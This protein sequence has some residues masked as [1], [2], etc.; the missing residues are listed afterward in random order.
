MKI[1]RLSIQ[2]FGGL[3]GFFMD[4]AGENM[5]LVYGD[6]E[7]G[8]S[9]ITEF[10]RS[11]M[12]PGKSAKY[13]IPKKSDN[14]ILELEMD[15][16]GVRILQRDQKKVV[17]KDGKLLPSVEL[18]MD[19][20]TYRSLFALDLEQL[21]D[22]KMITSG[23]LKRKFLTVPGGEHVPSVSKLI[24]SE[25]DA[26]L[27]KERLSD[28]K[29]IG[30]YRK[31]IKRLDAEIASKDESVEQYNDLVK[32]LD[33][34][35]EQLN[36]VHGMQDNANYIRNREFMLESLKENM[37]AIED[38]RKER[39]SLAYS[40]DLTD[41]DLMRY[42][43]L[44]AKI[45]T[46]DNLLGDME[47]E[48]ED[49]GP[50][51]EEKVEEIVAM[52]DDIE[53]VWGLKTRLDILTGTLNDLDTAKKEDDAYIEESCERLGLSEEQVCKIGSNPDVR[54]LLQNPDGKRT[55]P[56]WFFKLFSRG[57]R[58]LYSLAS[59]LGSGAGI[60]LDMPY[61][62][63]LSMAAG[64]TVNVMPSIMDTYFHV[65]NIV[66]SEWLPE[67]GFPV[68]MNRAQAA[69]LSLR[70]DPIYDHICRRR[71][72]EERI[73][74]F[75]EELNAIRESI[76]LVLSRM[77]I[78]TGNI[79]GDLNEMYS[80]YTL[81]KKIRHSFSEADGL[82]DKKNQTETEFE[83]IVSK[84]G[85]EEAIARMRSDREKLKTLDIQLDALTKSVESAAGMAQDVISK[86]IRPED[87][88]EDESP[89]SLEDR[90]GEINQEIGHV[91]AEMNAIRVDTE[92]DELRYQRS[93]AEER[94]NEAARRW[95]VLSLA[96]T[97]IN[98]CC[99]LFY[100]DLQPAVVRTA[101]RYLSLMT[102]G[103]YHI[104]SD[105]RDS[106]LVIEDRVQR[107]NADE[108]SSGLGDQV[109]LSVK[110]AVAK[111]M[112]GEKVPFLMDDVLVRFDRDR[113]QGACRAIM[114]FAKDQQVIMFTCDRS[115]ES[116]FR[117][118]GDIKYI[119]L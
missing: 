100:T 62:T 107:K 38:L 115:L 80:Q 37:K 24:R 35:N 63:V 57:K 110:M 47:P 82:T 54:E 117:L 17:E 116:V 12:F 70:V 34:L 97:I 73:V 18:H 118:E 32:R 69:D 95:A 29:V 11:T 31:E 53:N 40:E 9:T 91:N 78:D 8:K 48:V 109:Y 36:Y 88:E 83:A 92:I 42:D 108:W 51:S 77:N 68:G 39:E 43:E 114:E 25:M 26:L 119:R 50:M 5:V 111:E 33:V 16:G 30:K 64:I 67:N 1:R 15:D 58:Y 74:R 21:T 3:S 87:Q 52:G 45:A 28:A 19:A 20:E 104:I 10:M 90:I 71:I 13:P 96:D 94:F 59:I 4:L 22:D 72:T 89:E 81:A 103:R 84:Y 99:S 46:L 101:N 27:N 113:K 112:G 105:P 56:L 49:N 102:N 14:G 66:W 2:S 93:V 7:A 65:D 98:E 44:K 75:E 76:N 79:F 60:C 61:L 55:I 86:N 106:E 23:D 6:N 41:E 85:G